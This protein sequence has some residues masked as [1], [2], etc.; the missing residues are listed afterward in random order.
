M[1]DPK[2]L[3]DIYTKAALCRAFEKSVY[4]KVKENTIKIPVYLSAGQEYAAA[5]L[6][7]FY[8]SLLPNERQIFIQHRGHST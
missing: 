3:T 5:T 8:A 2:L 4:E 1:V 7:T 6:A